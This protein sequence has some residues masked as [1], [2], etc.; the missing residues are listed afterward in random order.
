MAEIHIERKN[1]RLWP[2]LLLGLAA[3][4]AVLLVVWWRGGTSDG[5]SYV[6]P[7]AAGGLGVGPSGDTVAATGGAIGDYLSYVESNRAREAAGPAHDYTAEGLRRLA[8]ALG[9]LS[10]RRSPGT[11][12]LQ[13]EVAALRAQA[14]RC[15]ATPSPPSTRGTP[16]RHSARPPRS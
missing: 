13:A 8:A 12:V 15:S 3:I 16:V 14:T 1:H 6:A 7:G 4:L 9:Q 10:E 11:G 5:S 2:W